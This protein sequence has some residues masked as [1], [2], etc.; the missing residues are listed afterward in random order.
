MLW[1]VVALALSIW[2]VPPVMFI[3]AAWWRRG[4]K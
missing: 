1:L 2:V 4:T 3:A